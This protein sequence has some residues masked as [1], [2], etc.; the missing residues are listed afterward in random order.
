SKITNYMDRYGTGAFEDAPDPDP[1]DDSDDRRGEDVVDDAVVP[2]EVIGYGE[3]RRWFEGAVD[4]GEEDVPDF[5]EPA[6]DDP[7]EPTPLP[8]AQ[9][10][11]AILQAAK[12]SPSAFAPIA[13]RSIKASI[14]LEAPK[15]S[16]AEK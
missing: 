11:P 7:S 15:P 16:S 5:G 10:L 13:E 3:T 4:V 2:A 1:I 12:A 8:H 14:M 6:A 9:A